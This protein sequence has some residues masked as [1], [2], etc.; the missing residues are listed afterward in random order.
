MD[1]PIRE[2][3]MLNR[4]IVRITSH[5]EQASND[6]LRDR[7]PEKLVGMVWPLTVQAWTFKLAADP[8]GVSPD[9]RL[10]RHLVRF[11]RSA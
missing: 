1:R 2:F 11:R 4:R 5:D 7:S 8:D 6:D 3:D 10:Q 9:R